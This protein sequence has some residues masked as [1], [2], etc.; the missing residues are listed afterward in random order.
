MDE[1]AVEEREHLPRSPIHLTLTTGERTVRWATHLGATSREAVLEETVPQRYTLRLGDGT[2]LVV[3]HDG[4]STWTVD[5]KAMVQPQGS[6]QWFALAEFLVAERI[7]AQRAAP[8]KPPTSSREA[9]PL[10]PPPPRKR[11][12][13]PEPAAPTPSAADP[14]PPLPSPPTIEAPPAPALEARRDSAVPAI[15]QPPDDLE[16]PVVLEAASAV[17]AIGEPAEIQ[18][19]ASD[20]TRAEG[21]EA[22]PRAD[23]A[24]TTAAAGPAAGHPLP[25]TPPIVRVVD[26]HP[27]PAAAPTMRVVVGRPV[28]RSREPSPRLPRPDD[29]ISPIPLVPLDDEPAPPDEEPARLDDELVPLDDAL[30]PLDQPPTARR[31]LGAN[32]QVLADDPLASSTER[33]ATAGLPGQDLSTIPLKPPDDSVPG[34]VYEGGRAYDDELPFSESRR[35]ASAEEEL[36]AFFRSRAGV[37]I[38]QAAAALGTVLSRVLD[39]LVRGLDKLVKLRQRVSAPA[40]VAPSLEP[41]ARAL[42][43]APLESRSAGRSG[44]ERR[45][46]PIAPPPS[47]GD[48]PVLRLS[49]TTEREDVAG[50]VYEG[51][52]NGPR[53]LAAAWRW[54]RRALLAGV[55]VVGAIYAASTWESWSP[56]AG[57]LGQQAVTEVD[58]RARAL[59]SAREQERLAEEASGQL[60]QLAPET[61]RLL[62]TQSRGEARNPAALHRSACDASDRGLRALNA[63]EAEELAAL[64]GEL[65]SLVRAEERERLREYDRMRAFGVAFPSDDRAALELVAGAA[66]RLA[67]ERLECLRVL[68]GKTI[69]AGLPSASL[70]NGPATR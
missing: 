38:L 10:I 22:K 8:R 43:S 40:P 65:L 57:E 56:K 64:R 11:E 25:V 14:L 29:N 7:E 34:K 51:D 27:Q 30:V 39:G 67:P 15:G 33:A 5:R 70:A 60:P 31:S 26:E 17:P 1:Q 2:V 9:L 58:R 37:A 13:P 23:L 55:L 53:L 12:E 62:L 46:P 68:L 4:L 36:E 47:L 3:D 69:A 16:V 24:L 44:P 35:P 49:Q 32:L 54:T 19:P 6:R 59:A 41:P 63:S 28:V 66:R 45:A 48:L 52:E 50:D 20:P 42:E 21:A 18:V 61:V